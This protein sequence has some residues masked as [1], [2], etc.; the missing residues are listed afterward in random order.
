M[1]R[2][3]ISMRREEGEKPSYTHDYENI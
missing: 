3:Q 2:K 1:Y